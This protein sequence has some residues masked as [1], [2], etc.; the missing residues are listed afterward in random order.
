VKRL[1]PRLSSLLVLTSRSVLLPLWFL[2]ARDVGLGVSGIPDATSGRAWA[3]LVSLVKHCQ[4]SP[5]YHKEQCRR[6]SAAQQVVCMLLQHVFQPASLHVSS[7]SQK[8]IRSRQIWRVHVSI[9]DMTRALR[10]YN[11]ILLRT[12]CDVFLTPPP[13]GLPTHE[14][15]YT[16]NRHACM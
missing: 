14:V 11:V 3:A 9:R 2:Q 13:A 7:L 15:L 1:N 6:M 5:Q 12:N 10:L 16:K 8:F 4:V